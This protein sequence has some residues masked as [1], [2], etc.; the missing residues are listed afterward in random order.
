MAKP[1][2]SG[3]RTRSFVQIFIV[4][5]L[6]CFFYILGAWQRTGFG[7][8]DLLQLEVTKKGAGCD[9]V[10]NLSFDSHHGGEVSKIDEVDLSLARLDISITR[11]AMINGVP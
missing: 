8:G 1:I 9:I 10:P 11:P 2:S 3:S 7:K 5:G 4:V 6:C